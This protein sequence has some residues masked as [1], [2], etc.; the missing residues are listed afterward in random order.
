[1]ALNKIKEKHTHQ[2]MHLEVK[3]TGQLLT[4][5]A[6]FQFK[7]TSMTDLANI[8]TFMISCLGACRILV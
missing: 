7:R 5:S 8:F 3:D 6:C 4:G 2:N 1:M